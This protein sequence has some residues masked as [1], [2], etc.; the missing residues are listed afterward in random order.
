MYL[1][2]GSIYIIQVYVY[3]ISIAMDPCYGYDTINKTVRF[4]F[5]KFD[6]YHVYHNYVFRW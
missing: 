3:N 6:F 4:L 5:Y 1:Y 2:E